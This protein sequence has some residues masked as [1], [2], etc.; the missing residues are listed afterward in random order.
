VSKSHPW[1]Q[2]GGQVSRLDE[3][4]VGQTAIG[5]QAMLVQPA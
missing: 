3:P 1:Q 4:V 5:G 2:R